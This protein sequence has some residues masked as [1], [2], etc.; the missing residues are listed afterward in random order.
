MEDL[1]S[2]AYGRPAFVERARS[3]AGS[4]ETRQVAREHLAYCFTCTLQRLT[5]E[6]AAALLLKEVHDADLSQI[7]AALDQRPSQVKN[8]LQEAR[9]T[10][11]KHY[12][13]TCALVQQQGMC[14]QCVELDGF[15]GAGQ[16]DPL[17][18]TNGG[19]EARLAIVRA[20]GLEG[21]SLWTQMLDEL[22][23]VL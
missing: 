1:R 11:R 4:P 20:E 10:M 23:A 13:T 22:L 14:H 7:G 2:E 6:Q 12:G 17:A 8:R 16:G 19:L 9:Q 5:P 21:R 18:G 15:F 3:H